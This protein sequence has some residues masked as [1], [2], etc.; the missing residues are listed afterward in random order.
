MYCPKGCKYLGK[1][2]LQKGK[3]FAGTVPTWLEYDY[4]E[5]KYLKHKKCKMKRD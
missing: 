3:C 1:A 4:N 5:G 2:K